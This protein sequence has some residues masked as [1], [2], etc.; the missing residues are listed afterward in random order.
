M[1]NS[2]NYFSIAIIFL[3]N[4]F[5]YTLPTMQ[6]KEV[7][8]YYRFTWDT[9]P[10]DEQLDVIMEGAKQEVLLQNERIKKI[11]A[12]ELWKGFLPNSNTKN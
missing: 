6:T 3:K 9:E 8:M 4:V 10:T 11:L 12:E 2:I 1:N 5:F 7:D